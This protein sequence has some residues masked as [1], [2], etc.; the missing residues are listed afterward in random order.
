[1]LRDHGLLLDIFNAGTAAV[2][3]AEGLTYAEFLADEKTQKAIIC[4]I[5]I[6]GEAT[7]R[8]SL[9]FRS[10]HNEIPW[11]PMAKTRDKLIHD[12]DQV[13]LIVLWNT[14][15]KDLPST[16]AAIAPLL[17]LPLRYRRAFPVSCC[18]WNLPASLS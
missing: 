1:M 4:Q 13:Q 6:M 18:H 11:S 16:L 17:Q 8:T 3:Y 9:E 5:L 12:Y 10:L 2:S 14:V 7:K 15:K